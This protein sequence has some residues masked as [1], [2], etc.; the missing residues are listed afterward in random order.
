MMLRGPRIVYPAATFNATKALEA[1]QQEGCNAWYGTPTMYVDMLA[2]PNRDGIEFDK[3]NIGL[4]AGAMCPEQL[5]LDLKSKMNCR[6]FVAYGTTENS[7]VTT[8]STQDDSLDQRTTTVGAVMPHTEA[9]V[10][11]ENGSVVPRG[12]TGEL[13]IRGTCVFK[14]YWEQPEK[15]NDV[16]DDSNWYKTGD[17]SIM[18]E[19][20]YIQIVGRSKDMIIR[21]GENI[22]P[23]EIESILVKHPQIVDAHVVG[24]ESKRLGEEVTIDTIVT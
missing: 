6:I 7:P 22:Y 11:N 1:V 3:E 17:L 8:L 20:G 5:L 24:V 9:K 18:R 15:T 13:C 2:H 12:E 19:D 4:M 14:G 16:L 23:A 21:G 10:V